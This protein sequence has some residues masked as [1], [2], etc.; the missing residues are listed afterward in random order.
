MAK[1][2]KD[3]YCFYCDYFNEDDDIYWLDPDD[4][5]GFEFTRISNIKYCPVCGKKLKKW[6]DKE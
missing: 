1:D 2:K 4:V 6:E 3:K 5:N